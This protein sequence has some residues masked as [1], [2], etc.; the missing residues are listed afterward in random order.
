M[1]VKQCL[2]RGLVMHVQLDYKERTTHAKMGGEC[3]LA[4][5]GGRLS[6]RLGGVLCTLGGRARRRHIHMCLGRE[7]PC[8]GRLCVLILSF[9]FFC[10]FRHLHPLVLQMESSHMTFCSAE[11]TFSSIMVLLLHDVHLRGSI[12]SNLLALALPQSLHSS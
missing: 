4:A 12:F 1:P 5:L 11:N 8:R 7:H 9:L 10:H 3:A 2:A 6:G